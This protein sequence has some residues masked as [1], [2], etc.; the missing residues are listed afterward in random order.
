MRLILT[1]ALAGALACGPGTRGFVLPAQQG[2]LRSCP[3]T[4]TGSE[5]QLRL[6][7][8]TDRGD[9]LRSAKVQL[10]TDARGS[11]SSATREWASAGPMGI[12]EVGPLEAATYDITVQDTGRQPAY[13]RVR[14]CDSSTL[15]AHAIL[16]PTHSVTLP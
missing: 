3:G 6:L 12:Y 1:A 5:A 11:I 7:V 10:R 2:L 13:M 8:L 16:P 4:P 14:F 9:T 15:E